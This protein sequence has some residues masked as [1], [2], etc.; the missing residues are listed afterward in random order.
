[1]ARR[2]KTLGAPRETHEHAGADDYQKAL[3]YSDRALTQLQKG[4]C[5][6]ALSNLVA[7]ERAL[8][9]GNRESQYAGRYP[10]S[11]VTDVAVS[12]TTEARAL[13]KKKCFRKRR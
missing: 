12:F 1:M 10:N 7:A 9:A 11:D 3:D 13:L 2:R 6:N 8:G 4:D 5:Q